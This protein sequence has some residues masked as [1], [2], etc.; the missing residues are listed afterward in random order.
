MATGTFLRKLNVEWREI[1]RGGDSIVIFAKIVVEQ[2]N[3]SHDQSF[4]H[5]HVSEEGRRPTCK[6]I[7]F[8]W[9]FFRFNSAFATHHVGNINLQYEQNVVPKF[10]YS[11]QFE[12]KVIASASLQSSIGGVL[13]PVP[14]N[15]V[16][17]IFPHARAKAIGS[18][19][20]LLAIHSDVLHNMFLEHPNR[21]DFYVFHLKF[22]AVK[23]AFIIISGQPFMIKAAM[24]NPLMR[25][26]RS[27]RIEDTL[28]N[29]L[30]ICPLCCL[31]VHN[32]NK[33]QE[34]SES[35]KES[36]IAS[37]TDHLDNWK[38]YGKRMHRFPGICPRCETD[39]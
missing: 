25:V 32:D 27:W 10:T 2:V 17:F 38:T 34:L 21:P 12:F 37:L 33:F 4:M 26:F 5:P 30:R 11:V 16:V 13:E 36:V 6:F 35:S 14:S 22:E 20:S 9:H 19:R 8:G 29:H 24:I 18:M 15:D 31:L 28:L 7:A 23:I 3:V 39:E 1:D